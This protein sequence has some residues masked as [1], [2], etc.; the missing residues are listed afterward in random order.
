[1]KKREKKVGNNVDVIK[2]TDLTNKPIKPITDSTLN[3]NKN[4]NISFIKSTKV[5]KK[6]KAT[7]RINLTN[8]PIIDSNPGENNKIHANKKEPKKRNLTVLLGSLSFILI[9]IIIFSF[10]FTFAYLFREKF[11]AV[12]FRIITIGIGVILYYLLII[13]IIKKY[14]ERVKG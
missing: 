6:T 4:N 11:L 3:E 14:S 8:Q 2:E 10:M 5:N 13:E 7:K 12:L 9:A 1:M